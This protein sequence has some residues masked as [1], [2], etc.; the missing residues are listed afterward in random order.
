MPRAIRFIL[1][2][3][4]LVFCW[5]SQVY[6]QSPA[7]S[8]AGKKEVVLLFN[9]K[10]FSGWEG[11]TLHTWRIEDG[12][13]TAGSLAQTVPHND[14]L[15]TGQRYSN[16]ILTLKFKLTGTEGF[17][18]AGVQFRSRRLKDP[19]YEMTGYQADIGPHYWASLYDESRRNKTLAAPD[20]SLIAKIL[21]PE[22]WN[23]YKIQC[24][25]KHIL[26]YLNDV[27]T[28]DYTETDDTIPQEGLIGLQVHGGGKT[29]IA[30]KDIR[31]EVK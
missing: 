22:N 14:F 18:N 2:V 7:A 12:T 13:I 20:S 8:P 26:I 15:V 25:N 23:D 6:A 16:F 10:T 30:Y 3:H 27:M 28:V 21:H 11:D 31:L 1:S 24:E 17:I 4:L 29:V 19:P 5:I 9:G